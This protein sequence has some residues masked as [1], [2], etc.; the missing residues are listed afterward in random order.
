MSSSISEDRA[1]FRD[2]REQRFSRL[3]E[4]VQASRETRREA[5]RKG[6]EP[7]RRSLQEGAFLGGGQPLYDDLLLAPF[8]GRVPS[9]VQAARR[10]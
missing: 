7:L 1:W 2:S 8:S 9:A 6:L 5:L 3:L 4:A 10:R